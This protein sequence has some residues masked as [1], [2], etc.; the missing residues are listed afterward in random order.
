[1]HRG[2]ATALPP[3]AAPRPCRITVITLLLRPCA[4]ENTKDGKAH[5]VTSPCSA[6]RRGGSAQRPPFTPVPFVLG[7]GLTPAGGDQPALQGWGLRHGPMAFHKCFAG[8][9]HAVRCRWSTHHP[10]PAPP[11]SQS[12]TSHCTRLP[13]ISPRAP[14]PPPS[15]LPS[16]SELIRGQQLIPHRIDGRRQQAGTQPRRSMLLL[17]LANWAQLGS[18]APRHGPPGGA[19]SGSRSGR[20]RSPS[21]AQHPASQG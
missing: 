19:I 7:N 5:G 15:F 21:A 6:P 9:M 8:S 20:S 10:P 3:K 2:K 4:A 11:H 16:L 17:L 18:S 1:M 14:P 13:P 12:S